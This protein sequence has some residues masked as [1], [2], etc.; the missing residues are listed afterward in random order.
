M[1]TQTSSKRLGSL[2]KPLP[3]RQGSPRGTLDTGGIIFK[4]NH[5]PWVDH[6]LISRGLFAEMKKNFLKRL[7]AEEVT[8]WARI[9]QWRIRQ[10]IESCIICARA[11]SDSTP[12]SS[13]QESEY[14]YNSQDPC[15]RCRQVLD[16]SSPFGFPLWFKKLLKGSFLNPISTSS[17]DH[18]AE[19]GSSDGYN[20]YTTTTPVSARMSRFA[21]VQRSRRL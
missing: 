9:A 3:T 5:T 11:L 12:G 8:A 6:R 2:D 13:N 4:R 7:F 20:M 17:A 1:G 15:S 14:K 21:T 18:M 10:G 16:V 19:P